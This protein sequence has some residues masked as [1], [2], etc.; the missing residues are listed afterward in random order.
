MKDFSN[1]VNTAMQAMIDSGKVEEIIKAKLEKTVE[2]AIDDALR[3]YSDFGKGL[4]KHIESSLKVDFSNCN[5]QEYGQTVLKMVEGLVN[6]HVQESA[7]AKLLDQLNKLFDTPPAQITLQQL[8][9][10]YKEGEEDEAQRDGHEKCGFVI[11]TDNYGF[12]SI[13]FNPS[14]EKDNYS[15]YSSDKKRV[16]KVR[17]C[18]IQLHL[19]KKDKQDGVYELRWI[20]F[21]GYK[22]ETTHNFMPTS[23]HGIAR[24]LYQMYS[25]G[26]VVTI[27]SLDTYDYET[28]YRYVD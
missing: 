2:S 26:T 4:T 19:S 12:I 3:S 22:P 7:Q 25:A 17:D 9:D 6:K 15:S 1:A 28:A 27:D 21:G 5:L 13:G 11:E 16:D 10:D 20:S 24:R 8:L 14:S 23:L 18:E